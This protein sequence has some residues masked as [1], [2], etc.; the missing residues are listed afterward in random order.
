LPLPAALANADRINAPPGVTSVLVELVTAKGPLRIALGEGAGQ[1]EAADFAVE[2]R[3]DELLGRL[4]TR[5]ALP[6]PERR[7]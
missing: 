1:H 2:G 3:P 7:R 4:F 6:R 5:G